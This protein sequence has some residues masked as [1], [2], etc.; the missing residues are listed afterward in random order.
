[1]NGLMHRSK[2]KPYSIIS[3]ATASD[4]TGALMPSALAVLRLM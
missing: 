4:D 1:M 2:Q 3:S